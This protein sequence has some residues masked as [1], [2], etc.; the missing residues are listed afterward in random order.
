MAEE[1]TFLVY[2]DISGYTRFIWENRYTQ[3]HAA[4]I[5]A[6]LLDSVVDALGPRLP[7]VKLEGDAAFCAGVP[8]GT[9]SGQAL[10][11]AFDAF[12]DRRDTMAAT[13]ACPCEAC[14]TIPDLDLKMIAHRGPVVRHQARTG[15]ELAGGPVI[16]L[17]RLAKN[18]V[19][20]RRYLLWTEDAAPLLADLPT[21]DIARRVETDP[22]L[23]AVPVHV[24]S[25]FPGDP[26][27][28]KASWLRRQADH[29]RKAVL[30]WPLLMRGVPGRQAS[31]HGDAGS[32]P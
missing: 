27:V 22:D 11:T 20:A 29:L 9:A 12:R 23:G 1:D 19:K 17:H 2:A 14:R 15:E 18:G 4:D 28:V 3:A 25:R 10:L 7:L 24:F 16:L 5:V 32:N 26:P 21:D 13:N 30:W 6:R 8:D 31:V